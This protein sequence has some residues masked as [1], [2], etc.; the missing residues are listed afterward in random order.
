MTERLPVSLLRRLVAYDPGSGA[1]IWL[2]RP[3]EM[4]SSRQAQR[5]WNTRYAGRA[6]LNSPRGAPGS[7]G[8]SG[9]HLRGPSLGFQVYAHRAAWA[10]YYGDWPVG[11]VD[12]RNGDATDN[13][14]TNL[15][16]VTNL[17]NGRNARQRTGRRKND[18]PRGVHPRGSAFRA[19]IKVSGKTHYLGVFGT[20][21][22]P[23][24]QLER[25]LAR[26]HTKPQS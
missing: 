25:I 9:A 22:L 20:A 14:I 10:L 16:L 18:L 6:A 4:F 11:Q 7:L 1:L 26:R 17:E 19:Q 8:C 12:H 13:R 5:T 3:P 21:A 15:R 24:K 23:R 2:P